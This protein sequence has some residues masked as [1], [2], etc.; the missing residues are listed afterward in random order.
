MTLKEFRDQYPMFRPN[1]LCEHRDGTTMEIISWPYLED[2]EWYSDQVSQHNPV[3]VQARR[4]G[5]P[6]TIDTYRISNDD[7]DLLAL[8]AVCTSDNTTF[9][10]VVRMSSPSLCIDCP[11]CGRGYFY[12]SRAEP[13]HGNQVTWEAMDRFLVLQ[14]L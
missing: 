12:F 11:T 10:P 9:V 3:L 14:R 2:K 1:V 4:P 5:D 7:P 13:N 6:T 8:M